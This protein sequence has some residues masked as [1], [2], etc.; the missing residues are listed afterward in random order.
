MNIATDKYPQTNTVKILCESFF[1]Q[2][3]TCYVN[4]VLFF[5]H[6]GFLQMFVDG[7]W[8]CRLINQLMP[9][10]NNMPHVLNSFEFL[11]TTF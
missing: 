5:I 11:A 2:N 7:Y 8:L 4:H 6:R 1:F 10:G 3:K 9:G